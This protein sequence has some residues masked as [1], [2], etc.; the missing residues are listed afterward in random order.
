MEG[1]GTQGDWSFLFQGKEWIDFNGTKL[2]DFGTRL[3]DPL[4]GRM[5]QID[6]ANQFA[7]GYTSM[8]NVP[9]MGIDPD[10]QL[11]FLIPQIGY[12]RKGGLSL[13]VELGIGIRGVLS[14][15]VT[16]GYNFG[17]KKGY[18]SAQGYASGFYTV[19]ALL[20]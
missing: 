2:Y 15:S 6:G 14:V 10:G 1:V 11:F 7:S 20:T 8:G 9:T 19:L 17:S 12:S 18:W 16:G 5:W 4:L 3:K 13:G